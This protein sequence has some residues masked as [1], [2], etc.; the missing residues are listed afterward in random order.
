M[1]SNLGELFRARRVAFGW[2][3]GEVARR[4]GYRNTSKAA[5]KVLR[6]ERQ[7][8]AEDGF[9]HRLA[10]VLGVTEHEVREVI[11]A[12]RLAYERAWH[13]WADQPTPIRTVVRAVPGFMPGVPVPA[14]ATT[15]EAVIAFAQA[16]AAQL[17]RKVFVVLSRRETV[18]ITEAGE[19]NGRFFATPDSDP[20]P[21]MSLKRVKFLFRL[22]GD[23]VFTLDRPKEHSTR[24][25]TLRCSP[26]GSPT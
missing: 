20:C 9:L 10:A 12:D 23:G 25:C 13:E 22:G 2:S 5:N 6:L 19:V 7:G 24:R 21:S 11:R 18:G 8:E 26:P 3:L 16:H 17:R 14:D 15:P 1:T 4:L